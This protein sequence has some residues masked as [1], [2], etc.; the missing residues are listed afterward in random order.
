MAIA[1]YGPLES[2]DGSRRFEI[3]RIG[4]RD[5]EREAIVL[6][7]HDAVAFGGILGDGLGDARLEMDISETDEIDAGI[8]CEHS[9]D[10]FFGE[11][12]VGQQVFDQRLRAGCFC[13]GFGNFIRADHAGFV[14]QFC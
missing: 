1:S 13:A 10:L 11:R 3:E 14:E 6:H 2:A 4:D 8:G 5:G 9:A 7:R 12:G